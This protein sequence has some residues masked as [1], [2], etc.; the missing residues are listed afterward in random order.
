MVYIYDE[1]QSHPLEEENTGIEVITEKSQS[2]PLE[3]ENTGIEVIT[4]SD[5]QEDWVAESA[6]TANHYVGKDVVGCGEQFRLSVVVVLAEIEATP[7]R[8]QTCR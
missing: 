4:G 2:H 1:S 5:G 3:G 6:I 7:Q 8:S